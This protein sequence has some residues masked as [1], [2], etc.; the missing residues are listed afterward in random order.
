MLLGFCSRSL[1][2]SLYDPGFSVYLHNL[3]MGKR[4]K[5]KEQA[6]LVEVQA[7]AGPR[8]SAKKLG[9]RKAE[10]EDEASTK[11]PA[12]KVK[13]VKSKKESAKSLNGSKID[14][15]GKSN[16]KSKKPVVEEEEGESD[17]S[18]GWENVEDGADLEASKM[19][20]FFSVQAWC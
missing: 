6:P 18:D 19:C 2:V 17:A 12:K 3:A 1:T 15:L 14:K 20:V 10:V 5:N 4:T 16:K 7:N 9:K 11:R 8:P 13:D